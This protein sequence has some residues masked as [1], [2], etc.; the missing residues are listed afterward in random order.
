MIK[1]MH[2]LKKK[3]KLKNRSEFLSRLAVLLKE[4]YTFYDS[5]S[6]LLPHH[7][8][9][10]RLLLTKIESDFRDGETVTH[11][12]S[13][14]EFSSSILL[15]VVIA[16]RDG[17]LA[18]TLSSM[19]VRMEKTE[20]AKK[21]LK[22]LLAYP[23]GLFIFISILLL[24]FRKFF[25]PNIEL[26]ASSR[27]NGDSGFVQSL[28]TLV[29]K[30]PDIILGIGILLTCFLVGCMI[31]YKKLPPAK[32]IKFFIAIPFLGNIF[33]MWKTRLFSS[34]LGSLLL[35]GLSMQDSLDI[36]IN[37][38]LDPVLSEIANEIKKSVIYG[39]PFDK[40]VAITDG[41]TKQFSSFVEHGTNSG[42]LPKELIIYSEYLENK[43]SDLLTKGLA[44]LQPLLFS[45]IAICILA[46]YIALLLP[47]YG[48]IDKI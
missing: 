1:G 10:Y 44:I 33:T 26:L 35:S 5:V 46:A 3:I 27:S 8:D 21:K 40:A 47:M 19:A 38:N 13:R 29:A 48:M 45:L 20:E 28:P 9:D 30:T 43:I 37:Q 18:E 11:I 39:E 15:P 32:K 17:R 12:L 25:L 23:A 41:L 7:V 24:G 34:E 2:E 4:G 6:L 22:G 16:E 42:H 31:F 14:L 36:L